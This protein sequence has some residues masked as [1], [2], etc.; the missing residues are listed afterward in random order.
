MK[1]NIEL[2]NERIYSLAHNAFVTQTEMTNN[3][4]KAKDSKQN[5]DI[6]AR[7]NAHYFTKSQDMKTFDNNTMGINRHLDIGTYIHPEQNP[8]Q[9]FEEKN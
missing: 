7:F 8:V 4:F 3:T 6:D 1:Q 2:I 9:I 5:R